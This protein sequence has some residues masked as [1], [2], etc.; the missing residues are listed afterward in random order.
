MEGHVTTVCEHY[1]TSYMELESSQILVL[2]W[3]LEPI[4]H[5]QWVSVLSL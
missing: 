1:T 4:S 3:L 2:V 5:G